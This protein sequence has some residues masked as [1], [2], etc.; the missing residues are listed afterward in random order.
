MWSGWTT[1]YERRDGIDP[2]NATLFIHQCGGS[3]T[4]Y[5][6]KQCTVKEVG[7]QSISREH[8]GAV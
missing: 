6:I 2:I 8:R 4:P 7:G 1:L 5:H 3:L